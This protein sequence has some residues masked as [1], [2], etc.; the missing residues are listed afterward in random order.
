MNRFKLE[1]RFGTFDFR[2]LVEKA[3]E[4]YRTPQ[5]FARFNDRQYFFGKRHGYDG[6][7]GVTGLTGDWF[8]GSRRELCSC[9]GR[10]FALNKVDEPA[11]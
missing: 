1:G 4:G 8:K 5:R 7:H 11:E 6:A 3:P 9:H 10:G 2:R